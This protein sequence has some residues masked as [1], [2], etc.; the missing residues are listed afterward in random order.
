MSRRLLNGLNQ[1]AALRGQPYPPWLPPHSIAGNVEAS[2]S[3]VAT[4]SQ[5]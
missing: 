1:C 2:A 4:Q 5:L 3:A